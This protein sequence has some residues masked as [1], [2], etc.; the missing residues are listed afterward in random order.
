MFSNINFPLSQKNDF[1][2]YNEILVLKPNSA[3]VALLSLKQSQLDNYTQV[4]LKISSF[5]NM[6]LEVEKILLVSKK[7]IKT[8]L[9][10]KKQTKSSLKDY[11]LKPNLYNSAILLHKQ[12][13]RLL[14]IGNNG[15]YN[16]LVFNIIKETRNFFI[17][18]N[19]F[20]NN[21]L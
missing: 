17:L 10:K 13:G 1:F 8:F 12:E 18:Q 11:K 19:L 15:L 20:I 21:F 3:R 2:L 6:N 4:L 9:Y 16:D 14:L 7:L 5:L